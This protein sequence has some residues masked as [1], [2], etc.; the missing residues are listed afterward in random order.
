MILDG[1]NIEQTSIPLD[2]M[3]ES[4][5]TSYDVNAQNALNAAR[6]NAIENL[7]LDDTNKLKQFHTQTVNHFAT[8]V[9]SGEATA[10][11][12]ADNYITRSM[13]NPT[14][15]SNVVFTDTDRT[16]TGKNTFNNV[17][18]FNSVD[19]APGTAALVVNTGTTSLKN[20]VVTG[21][22]SVSSNTT[23]GGNLTV[24]GTG[25]VFKGLTVQGELIVTGGKTTIN[26]TSDLYVEDP[27]IRV[28]IGGVAGNTVSGNTYGI[29]VDD[30]NTTN[31][32]KLASL[33]YQG[34]ASTGNISGWYMRN[35]NGNY[36]NIASKEYVDAMTS[37]AGNSASAELKAFKRCFMAG[38][39]TVWNGTTACRFPDRKDITLPS[40]F[41]SGVADYEV[42]IVPLNSAS[43]ATT[44]SGYL[45][46]TGEFEVVKLTANTFRV[47]Y[48]GSLTS[49]QYVYFSW[50]AIRIG[51][52]K[53]AWS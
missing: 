14:L 41:S 31:K 24:N 20:T 17:T 40:G 4:V 53:T 25:S 23:V 37:G 18:T 6:F 33:G 11:A 44:P 38:H 8:K 3:A 22:A 9:G 47:V 30:K 39:T 52:L 34:G 15:V 46:S 32:A 12:I 26:K 21:T 29:E 16:L 27:M 48:T 28:N 36:L 42:F 43:N 19:N 1:K 13:F 51:P 49:T 10:H 50:I 35:T 7:T 45:T 5:A 2:R